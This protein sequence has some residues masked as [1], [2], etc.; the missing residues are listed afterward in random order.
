MQINNQ[1]QVGTINIFFSLIII[2]IITLFGAHY[3]FD[4]YFNERL[5]FSLWILLILTLLIYRYG[6]FEYV[7]FEFTDDNVDIKYYRLFPLGRK[8]NRIVI[9]NEFLGDFKINPGYGGLFSSLVLYQNKVG[10]MAEYPPIG[11]AAIS[12]KMKAEIGKEFSNIIKK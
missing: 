5:I 7:S 10:V 12:H 11:L 6:G 2:A 8:Y 9:Q 3:I 4:I 1:K